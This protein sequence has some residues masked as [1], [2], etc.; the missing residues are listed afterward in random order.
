M[1]DPTPPPSGRPLHFVSW[2]V[3]ERL[4][5]G[6]VTAVVL[7]VVARHLT[8]TGFGALNLSLAIVGT[9]IPLVQLGLESMVVRELVRRPAE[10]AT[11]LGTA[12]LLRLA[13]GG[14]GALLLLVVA[15]FSPALRDLWP[16]LLPASVLLPLQAGDVTDCWFRSRVE[17]RPVALVRSVAVFTGAI[18]KLALV[19]VGADVVAFAWVYSLEAA[20]FTGALFWRFRRDHAAVREWHWCAA[21]ARALLREGW[22]Y[23]L[24]ATIGGLAFR[25]DQFAVAAK[26]GDDAAGIYYG[27]LRIVEIPAFVATATAGA[28]FPALAAADTALALRARLEQVFGVVSA[29]AWITGLGLTLLGPWCINLLLGPAYAAAG[30]ALALQGWAALFYFT[31]MVRAHYL[32]V[33]AAPGTQLLTALA[34]L[35]TQVALNTV[36]VPSLGL[37]GAALAFLGTQ[38]VGA[39]ILPLILPALR[40]CLGPQWRGLMAPWQPRRW[41]ELRALIHG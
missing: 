8:P 5:R 22:G 35:V 17:S 21:T 2:L 11:L 14:I 15:W 3:G 36:L 19:A 23:A 31:G 29:L 9:L 25:F 13:A 40:P 32:A 18:A 12:A 37:A 41:R 1:P 27:A 33:H 10:S 34:A 20:A 26:L 38:F 39:W 28:L 6:L 24:A 16:V 4:V 30:P 7:A